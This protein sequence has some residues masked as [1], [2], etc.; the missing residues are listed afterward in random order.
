MTRRSLRRFRR[1]PSLTLA[2]LA[3][4][5]LAGGG[6][7]GCTSG[8][9]PPA[10]TSTRSAGTGTPSST[11]D[12]GIVLT[13][14]Q[15]I[16]LRPAVHNAVIP[17]LLA[18]PAEIA[19]ATT[20]SLTG[21]APLFGDDRSTPVARLAARDFL[22]E[23]TTV[24][25]VRTDGAWALAL[26]PARRILP[27]TAT[28]EPAPAQTAGWVPLSYLT[29]PHPVENRIEISTSEQRLSIL[30]RSGAVTATFAV[31]VG[32]PDTP[33][34]TGVTGY[35]QT[36]Y[37]DPDQGQSTHRIQLTSLHATASDEPYEGDDGG[38]IGIHY[39][40]VSSGAISHGC[41]R[42]DAAGID[43]V[44]ALPLGT[45]VTIVG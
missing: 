13:P 21:E 14:A 10:P 41:V 42:M 24:V 11:P 20:Y 45:L 19:S 32:T 39:Q 38:L 22:H 2:V 34:P 3:A 44:D 1:R 5:L 4:A 6:L 26:T 17:E 43:A 15:V 23:P 12:A 9:T 25:V 35:L 30:D 8:E 27:S 33:T 18:A 36:R 28:T 16:V 7:S 29:D 31:G 40:P 37:L